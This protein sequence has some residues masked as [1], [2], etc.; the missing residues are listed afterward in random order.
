MQSFGLQESGATTGLEE[1]GLSAFAVNPDVSGRCM[2]SYTYEMRS[3]DEGIAFM[4]SDVTTGAEETSSRSTAGG[5][6]I[7]LEA[8][9]ITGALGIT[10]PRS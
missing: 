1:A 7:S 2:P 8:D 9:D 3:V 5:L 6:A 4:V 10:T